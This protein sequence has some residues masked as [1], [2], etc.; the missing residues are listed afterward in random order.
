MIQALKAGKTINN[1][2]CTLV[3]KGSRY[4]ME[5]PT[6]K[7]SLDV[8]STCERRLAAHW[9][10]FAGPASTDVKPVDKKPRVLRTYAVKIKY[11]DFVAGYSMEE[12]DAG[13]V[14]GYDRNEAMRKARDIGRDLVGP[15]GPGYS[16]SVKLA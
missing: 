7:H 9:L 6:G 16:V 10:G 13:T 2:G 14:S 11:T 12:C 5:G 15:H 3:I 8:D 4:V 1:N